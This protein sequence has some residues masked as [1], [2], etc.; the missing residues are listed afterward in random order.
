MPSGRGV[1]VGGSSVAVGSGVVVVGLQ[2]GLV[3]ECRLVVL[4]Y[5]LVL[6][7]ALRPPL[8][9]LHQL[10]V[11]QFAPEQIIRGGWWSISVGLI[12]LGLNV[13]RYFN[14]LR[15]SGFTTFLLI[16]SLKHL[17]SC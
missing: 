11:V 7:L 13:A 10:G 1:R 15:M 14:N 5:L 9:V 16:S 12:M 4:P 17:F 6:A 3:Q 8:E 2:W